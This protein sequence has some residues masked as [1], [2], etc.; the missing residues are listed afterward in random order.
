MTF[1]LIKLIISL[2]LILSISEI[3]NQNTFFSALL[4]SLPI[5]S[6]ISIIRIYIDSNNIEKIINFS[7]NILWLIIPSLIFFIILP[8]LLKIEIKSSLFIS[9]FFTVLSYYILILILQKLK[10]NI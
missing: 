1:Y 3:G 2:V 4:A 8:M 10:I 9:I 7:H 6:I 5:V